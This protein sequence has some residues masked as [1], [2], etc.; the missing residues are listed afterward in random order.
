MRL[1]DLAERRRRPSSAGRSDAGSLARSET[2]SP[3]AVS[4]RSTSAP[5]PSA[6]WP[7]STTIVVVVGLLLGR[8]VEARQPRASIGILALRPR[9]AR[10]LDEVEAA[11]RLHGAVRESRTSAAHRPPAGCAQL[12]RQHRAR[13]GHEDERRAGLVEDLV[14]RRDRP[15]RAAAC[16]R[17]PRSRAGGS[18]TRRS[19]MR[20]AK[21]RAQPQ[22]EVLDAH[23][24]IRTVVRLRARAVQRGVAR[25]RTPAAD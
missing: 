18:V 25:S 7:G 21:S 4:R 13:V 23:D 17:P 16:A 2:P 24:P 10:P 12:D 1:L 5:L 8:M 15:R 22:V 20:V 11:L 3:S 6:N 14:D 9:L 19:S